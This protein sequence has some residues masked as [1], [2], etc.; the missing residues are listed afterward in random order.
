MWD[1]YENSVKLSSVLYISKLEMNLLFERR[2]YK[3]DLQ[4]SFDD[5]DL[6]MYNK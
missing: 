6:Y 4:K 1:H 3:K 2:M 5:K